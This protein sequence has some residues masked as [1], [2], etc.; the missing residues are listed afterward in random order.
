[1]AAPH[2]GSLLSHDDY[3]RHDNDFIIYALEKVIACA[4]RTQQIF[5]AQCFWWIASVV[6]LEQGLV[7]HIDNL[8]GRILVTKA[9]RTKEGP[10]E[11]QA[12]GLNKTA[13]PVDV[14]PTG[15]AIS[16]VPRDT[17]ESQSQDRYLKE[18][19]EFIRESQKQRDNI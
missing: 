6:G 1:V 10:L 18:C 13:I 16:P 9:L 4:R 8:N 5:L 15:Q 7:N 2:L 3:L 11:L 17:P 14:I 19:D 12:D